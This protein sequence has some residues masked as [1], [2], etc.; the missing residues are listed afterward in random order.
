VSRDHDEPP[1]VIRVPADVERPDEI[2]AGLSAR[3]LGIV[4]ATGVLLWL[5]YTATRALVPPVVFA[6]LALPVGA[7]AAALVLVRRDGLGLDALLAAA[8]RQRLSPRR[9]IPAHEPARPVP[10]WVAAP[11][12]RLPAP[13]RL[14]ARAIAPSGVVDLGRDGVAVVCACSTVNFSLRSTTEQ[15]GLVAAYARWL[16]SVTGPVQ[17][18][19]RADRLDLAPAI[20]R[21]REAAPGLP[22]RALEDAALDHAAFLADLSVSRDLLRRQVLLVLRE[23][24]AGTAARRAA[25]G[26]VLR[27]AQE[28]AAALAAAEVTVHI[29]DGPETTAVLAASADPHGP[30]RPDHQAPPE[31][32]VTCPDLTGEETRS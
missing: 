6:G 23:P 17:V 30:P 25:A 24:A 11:A 12:G 13:L 26:R 10:R 2:L 20:T 4:A 15:N 27:R 21:L 32:V 16:N 29:L 31:A 1:L 19:V 9:L 18:L 28:A 22:H 14:P 8:V 5:A 3:Q 7:V